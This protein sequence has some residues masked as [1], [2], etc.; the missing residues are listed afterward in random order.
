MSASCPCGL[1]REQVF[2]LDERGRVLLVDGFCQNPI[3]RAGAKCGE[4]LGHHPSALDMD[5]RNALRGKD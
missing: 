2:A 5:P 3:N 4:P 1:S